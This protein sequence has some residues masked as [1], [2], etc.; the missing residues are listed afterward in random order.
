MGNFP[1]N[2]TVTEPL[3]EIMHYSGEICNNVSK[4]SAYLRNV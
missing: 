2:L 1:H 3:Y 4:F